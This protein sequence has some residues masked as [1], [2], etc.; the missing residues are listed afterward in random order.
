MSEKII[1]LNSGDIVISEGDSDSGLFILSEGILEVLKGNVTV[2]EFT[3]P[4]TIFGELSMI[5]GKPRTCT[6]VAK[7]DATVVRV[8]Q[9]IDEMIQTNPE[10]AK[11]LLYVLAD[12]LEKTT[13]KMANPETNLIW[14]FERPLYG[15]G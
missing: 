10:L 7:T 3:R 12:R 9:S 2:A 11:K 5:L 8:Y 13:E 14:C 6:V 4:D 15:D 1:R